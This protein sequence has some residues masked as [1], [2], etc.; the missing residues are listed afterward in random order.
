[1]QVY[2]HS[3]GVNLVKSIEIKEFFCKKKRKSI[4]KRTAHVLCNTK[5]VPSKT[6]ATYSPTLWAVPSAWS[7]LTS[8]FGMGRGGTPAL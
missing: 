1:M 3:S 4:K 5:A 8:L 7:G 6:A 2:A